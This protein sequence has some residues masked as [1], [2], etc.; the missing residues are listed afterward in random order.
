MRGMYVR[1]FD[2]KIRRAD[3][4]PTIGIVLTSETSADIA[5]YSVLHDS[6]QLYASSYLLYLPSED[7]LR[8][9]IETEKQRFALRDGQTSKEGGD[10]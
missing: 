7:E 2:D 6:D 3:D 4:N 10:R 1:M 9:A 8:Q 5:R